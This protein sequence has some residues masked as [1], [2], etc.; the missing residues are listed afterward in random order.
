MLVLGL[1]TGFACKAALTSVLGSSSSLKTYADR[2]LNRRVAADAT[3]SDAVGSKTRQTDRQTSGQRR[4][5]DGCITL[6]D[7]VNV[8]TGLI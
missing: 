8:T 1:L 2:M 5:P 6:A 4:T 3:V 7:A